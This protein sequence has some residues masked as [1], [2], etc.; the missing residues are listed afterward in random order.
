MSI[1]GKILIVCNVL[2]A[3][4]FVYL[5]AL[6]WAKRHSWA[7]AVF[8]D[9]L[10]LKGLPVDE[11]ETDP[12]E[13]VVLA[14][15]LSDN[16]LSQM[17]QKVGGDPVRTQR[18]EVEKVRDQLRAE[19]DALPDEQAKRAKLSELLLPLP[20]TSGDRFTLHAR[21]LDPKVSV[22]DLLA[23]VNAVFEAASQ[24]GSP[25]TPL[26]GFLLPRDQRRAIAHLLYNVRPTEDAHARLQV[27]I[28]VQ[29]FNEEARQQAEV[30]KVMADEVRYA[31]LG[32]RAAF[33]VEYPALVN[34]IRDLV[35]T[36][37]DRQLYLDNQLKLKQQHQQLRE[38]RQQDVEEAKEKLKVARD[39]HKKALSEQAKEE[40]S[41]FE[42]QRILGTV[43]VENELK[44]RE[45][46]RL[47]RVKV[48]G[49]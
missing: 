19:I 46:R 7:Y 3:T 48:S 4:A 21:I 13:N 18:Q 32:D 39:L 24:A 49:K 17:F 1:F 12:V 38:G 42:S 2:L 35:E 26:V 41:L 28:G 40:Q 20:R 33:E 9:D 10:M 45:I 44:E 23:D 43:A 47:E 15:Q 6:D 25:S 37:A 16:T 30:L 14:E 36:L 22:D 5:A 11:E 27:V 31:L 8:R 34:D 29:A